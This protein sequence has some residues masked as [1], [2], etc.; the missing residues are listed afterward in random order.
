MVAVPLGAMFRCEWEPERLVPF[1]REL[2]RLGYDELWLVED[3]FFAAGV[4]STA[5]A[6]A[7]T[8]RIRVGIG[9][10]PAVLRNPA[11]AAM[12]VAALARLFPGRV[13]PGLGHGVAE[14]MDQVGALPRS[15]LAA[16]GETV[17]AVRGLLA[18]EQVTM[19]GD[20]VRLDAVRLNHPP[21]VV[22]PFAAGVRGPRSLRMSGRE[23]DGTILSE[24]SS[25]GY[26]RW[27]RGQ[28]DAGRAEAGR[29]DAH[30]LTVYSL[31]DAGGADRAEARRELATLLRAG[32]D[33][34]VGDDEAL[35]GTDEVAGDVAGVVRAA[36]TADGVAAAAAGLPV[37]FVHGLSVSGDLVSG[38]AALVA[39]GADAVVFVPPPDPDDALVHLSAAAEVLHG[40]ADQ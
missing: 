4:A 40:A 39:A 30:R 24:L 9:I 28:V 29:T 12:E 35:G 31:L 22:P 26:V 18:G 17:R 36:R 25:P 6:L 3:C 23:A 16:L 27:A 7:S 37:N 34:Q 21:R 15:Q 10:L 1:A 11:L 5:T 33:P 32:R 8:D 19:D 38:V 20:H 14:W 13:L 2:D